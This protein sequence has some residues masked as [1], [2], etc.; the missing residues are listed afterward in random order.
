MKNIEN[1]TQLLREEHR[2]IESALLAFTGMSRAWDRSNI[3]Q[4]LDVVSEK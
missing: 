4:L 3:D 2:L 1:S